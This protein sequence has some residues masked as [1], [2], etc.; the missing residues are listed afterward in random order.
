MGEI[1]LFQI[2]EPSAHLPVLAG[3]S[4]HRYAKGEIDNA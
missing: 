3:R 2:E 1:L 4:F